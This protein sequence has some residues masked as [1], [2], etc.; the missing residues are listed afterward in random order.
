MR[1]EIVCLATPIKRKLQKDFNRLIGKAL[2]RMF[3]ILIYQN[4]LKGMDFLLSLRAL[5]LALFLAYNCHNLLKL[6]S[7]LH[8]A[9]FLHKL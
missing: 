5:N 7:F 9:D 2:V 1:V 8:F 4:L 6:F 3:R